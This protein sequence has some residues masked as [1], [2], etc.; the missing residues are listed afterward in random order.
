MIFA[1][2]MLLSALGVVVARQPLWA[3]LSLMSAFLHA[4]ALWFSIDAT[5][6]AT[7]LIII[8]VGAVTVFFLIIVM[9]Y[10]KAWQKTPMRSVSF[11]FIFFAV[12]FFIAAH[13]GQDI[14]LPHHPN[15]SLSLLSLGHWIY[16]HHGRDL[17]WLGMILLVAM[18][19]ALALLRPNHSFAQPRHQ[20]KTR[21]HP[22][23]MKTQPLHQG[24]EHDV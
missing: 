22:V 10:Q 15:P 12:E 7:V 18:V 16:H 1:I 13:I 6:L 9:M 20:K 24:L 5:F 8:N 3:V 23:V 19:G 2:G 4:A 21:R 14:S 17:L 11:V